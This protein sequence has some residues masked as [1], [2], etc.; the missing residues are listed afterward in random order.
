MIPLED[1]FK[2]KGKHFYFSNLAEL[3][4]LEDLTICI[5]RHHRTIHGTAPLSQTPD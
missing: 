5:V 3:L 2:G 4:Q 1:L